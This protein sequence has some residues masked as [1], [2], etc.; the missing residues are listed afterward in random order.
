[1]KFGMKIAVLAFLLLCLSILTRT[2]NAQGS[3]PDYKPDPCTE[4]LLNYNYCLNVANNDYDACIS[5]C[6]P[7]DS[8]CTLGCA[9]QRSDEVDN[10]EDVFDDCEDA[11]C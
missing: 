9:Y 1:M 6:D 3:G 5:Q 4:C 7:G 11:W 10:C 8:D 2:T